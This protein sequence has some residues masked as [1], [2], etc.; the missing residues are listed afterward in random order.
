V[1]ALGVTAATALV[2][3]LWGDV[4][5][6]W[7][8]MADLVP[9]LWMMAP[10][11]LASA[12]LL[13]LNE[14]NARGR[15][16][17]LMAGGQMV[18]SLTTTG[19]R[20]VGGLAGY[21]TGGVMIGSSV[22]GLAVTLLFQGVRTLRASNP[23]RGRTVHPAAM[24]GAMRR[25]ADL[26]LFGTWAALLN[27]VSW[28]LPVF[29]LTA[30]FTPAVAAQYA[31]GFR[32]LQAPM[33]LV[34]G[35][36]GKVFYQRAAEA[37]HAGALAPLAEMTFRR[38]VLLGLPPTLFL[39]LAGRD[40]FALIFGPQWAEAG[41]Y[42]Q[43]LALWGFF[44]FITSPLGN[45]NLVLD[46]QR[47]FFGWNAVNFGTRFAS[48]WIGGMAGS[49]LL[50]LGLFGISGVLVYGY[51]NLYLLRAAGVPLRRTVAILGAAILRFLPIAITM[52]AL[53]WLGAPL[54][55]EIGLPALLTGGYLLYSFRQEPRVQALTSRLG[56]RL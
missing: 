31:L 54:W 11:L 15:R 29:M 10:W 30:F 20:L 18:N 19:S 37:H 46:R 53:D 47:F 22:L 4:L 5:L 33:S 6:G 23:L 50:A 25:Y 1:A 12:G 21:A 8:G 27:A 45:L 7:L 13:V 36:I 40:L 43:L 3:W 48:L 38:L 55:L 9:Y 2:L 26:P 44:W 41:I 51:L 56:W 52:V 14:W 16:F 17:G 39:M 49:A 28:Q 34:G 35:A 24:F 32:V 42:V